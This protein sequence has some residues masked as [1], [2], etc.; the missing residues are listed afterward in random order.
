MGQRGFFSVHILP[1]DTSW[2]DAGAVA[3]LQENL[4]KKPKQATVPVYICHWEL[5]YAEADRHG[6]QEAPGDDHLL[7]VEENPT[8][9]LSSGRNAGAWPR[10]P[11][12]EALSWKETGEV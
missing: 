3:D 10:S 4:K 9:E 1:L 11:V 2:H 6:C 7:L 5:H 12:V 8:G